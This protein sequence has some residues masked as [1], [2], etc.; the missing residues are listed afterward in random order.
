[1][2]LLTE[3]LD[4]LDAE[5]SALEAHVTTLDESGWW[6]PTPASGWAVI[7]AI[8]HL[9]WTDET[10]VIAMT[11]P[12]RLARLRAQQAEEPLS[13][14]DESAFLVAGTGPERVL[15]RWRRSRRAVAAALRRRA[16]TEKVPWFGPSMSP[17]SMATARLMETWA[18]GVDVTD[19]L[20]RPTTV[21]DR[22]RHIAH[23]GVRTRSYSF[24]QRGLPPPDDVYVELRGPSGQT[25]RYG[26]P[27]ADSVVGPALD[28]ALLVTRRRHPS[29]LSLKATGD[30]ARTWVE[31]AQAYAGDP[32]EG[33]R[34]AAESG[35]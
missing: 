7:H 23:L 32:G 27:A 33:R 30:T 10:A 13:F 14:A 3:L 5:S 20:G 21:S 31:I 24:A 12:G 6:T 16:S 17:V 26:A 29:D 18:H 1:M 9:A 28:F 34:P 15:R 8:A 35:R 22:L 19:A 25:W 4:D 11:D 2:S